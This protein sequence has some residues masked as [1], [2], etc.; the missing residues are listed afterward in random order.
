MVVFARRGSSF[1][2]FLC[3]LL[4]RFDLS[5]TGSG[6]DSGTTSTSGSDSGSGCDGCD[7]PA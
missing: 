7:P 6:C 4:P 1:S 3:D 2:F 5:C